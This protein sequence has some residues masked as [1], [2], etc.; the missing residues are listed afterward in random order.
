[1]ECLD[2]FKDLWES[3]AVNELYW[4]DGE[5]CEANESEERDELS[6]IGVQ[7]AISRFAVEAFW[8]KMKSEIFAFEE[9]VFGVESGIEFCEMGV[10]G[11][12]EWSAGKSLEKSIA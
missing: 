6:L 7:I 12:E 4:E 5:F 8:I 9:E 2:C 10:E 3:E 11:A 1:M